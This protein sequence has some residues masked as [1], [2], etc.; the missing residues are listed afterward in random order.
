MAQTENKKFSGWLVASDIDGTLN[1]KLRKL[2][3]RNLDA[4]RHFVLDLGGHFTLASGRNVASLEKHF[5]KLP[6]QNTPAIVLNGAGLYDFQM[7]EMISFSAIS[8][9]GKE[10]VRK[11]VRKFPM[12]EVEICTPDNIL[13]LNAYVYGTALVRADNLPHK[14]IKRIEEALTYDWGKVVLFGLPPLI[15]RVKA[16]TDSLNN[17]GD[18]SCM[19]SSIA[20]YEILAKDTNKG[21]AVKKL[22]NILGVEYDHTAAI[23]DYFNDFDMLLSVFLPAAC[24]QAPKEVHEIAKYHACHCNKGA[25]GDFLEYIEKN[26]A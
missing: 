16:Y 24:G 11:I 26:Y 14:R 23:G 3:G 21:T 1:T 19:S 7:N 13:L 4:I 18:V 12:T 10:I 20:T 8:S 9:K 25:V 5:L 2:P 22:A 6:I 17:S 15:N